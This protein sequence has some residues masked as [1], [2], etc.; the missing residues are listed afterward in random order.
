MDLREYWNGDFTA[1]TPPSDSK[2]SMLAYTLHLAEE[3]RGVVL[4]F[5]REEAPD[6]FVVKLP[7]INAAKEYNL[8]F[9]D[10]NY[11]ETQLTVSGKQLLD[12]FPVTIDTAPGSLV[13]KYKGI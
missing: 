1:L 9:S 5:R 8:V 7:Q 3:D 11:V 13:I 2:T 4:V 6:T 10:E 12:G